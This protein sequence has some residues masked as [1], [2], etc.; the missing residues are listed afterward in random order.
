M[1]DHWA[2][3]ASFYWLLIE[4]VQLYTLLVVTVLSAKKY[5]YGYLI[6]GWLF[7]WVNIIVWVI[8]KLKYENNGCWEIYEKPFYRWVVHGPVVSAIVV[9]THSNEI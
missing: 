7:S 9:R 6:F 5:F 3:T 2:E 4:G 8:V 1:L